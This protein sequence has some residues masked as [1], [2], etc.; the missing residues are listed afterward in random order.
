MQMAGKAVAIYGLGAM[1]FGMAGALLR[2]GLTTH[3]FDLNADA[4]Q[5][6]QSA[7][8]AQSTLKDAA[9]SIGTVVIVVLNGDQTEA[10]LF[11][12]DGI[13]GDLVLGTVVIACATV[14]PDVARDLAKRCEALGLLY[15]VA[16]SAQAMARCL[17]SRPVVWQHLPKRNQHWM[18]WHHKCLSLGMRLVQVHQ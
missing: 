4:A 16:R 5:R 11:G 13:A 18:R 7:G 17:F 3:G 14:A 9:S 15:L 10:V 8:G 1:G 12:K 2:A 6:F